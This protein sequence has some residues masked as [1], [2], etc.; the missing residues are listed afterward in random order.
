MYIQG[1]CTVIQGFWTA[2]QRL[3]TE[4]ISTRKNISLTSG[5]KNK[6]DFLSFISLIRNFEAVASKFLRSRRCS[7]AGG[8][9]YLGKKRMNSFVLL[10]I[11]RNFETTSR[12][13][14]RSEMKRKT[15]FSFAFLSLIRNFDAKASK[16]LHLGIKKN[17]FFCSS[18]DFS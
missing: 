3:W 17:E 2:V 1:L 9:L 8:I 11:F 10:S 13:Y 16:L 18:L 5:N 14:F 7:G 12:R 4:N 6:Q 15:S